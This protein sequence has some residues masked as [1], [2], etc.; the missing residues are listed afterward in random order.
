[1]EGVGNQSDTGLGE[2]SPVGRL[3][4]LFPQG[5]LLSGWPRPRRHTQD[6]WSGWRRLSMLG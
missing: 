5:T 4:G 1:M 6:C 3:Q 2:D